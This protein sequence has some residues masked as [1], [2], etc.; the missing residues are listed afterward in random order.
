MD[1]HFPK[2]VA[3]VC[4]ICDEKYSAKKEAAMSREEFARLCL[5]D[6]VRGKVSGEAYV[7][8]G[9][10]GERV[11]AVRTADLTNP[12]EWEVITRPRKEI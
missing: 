9:N 12:D 1:L 10:Y 6:I 5:G 2:G 11:T 3:T 7:V 4:D 8:T